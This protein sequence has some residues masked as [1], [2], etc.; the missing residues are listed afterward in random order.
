[1]M[2]AYIIGPFHKHS[3]PLT[4]QDCL[5]TEYIPMLVSADGNDCVAAKCKHTC[6]DDAFAYHCECNQGYKLLE[7]GIE[8]YGKLLF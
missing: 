8:C 5:K 7:N 1:M 3:L 2:Y 4:S 6:V